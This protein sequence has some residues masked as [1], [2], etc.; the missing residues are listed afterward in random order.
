[1]LP[2]TEVRSTA[3]IEGPKSR[4]ACGA[5]GWKAGQAARLLRVRAYHSK[6]PSVRPF[7]SSSNASSSATCHF[8]RLTVRLRP[9]SRTPS[10]SF[11]VPQ[12]E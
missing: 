2:S 9:V 8:L 11:S 6:T 7:S 5:S 4:I 1:M 10:R 12:S 3:K